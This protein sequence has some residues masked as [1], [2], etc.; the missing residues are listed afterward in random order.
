MAD[1]I[2]AAE[3]AAGV[4]A[5]VH[6]KTWRDIATLEKLCGMTA[7]GCVVHV[8]EDGIVADFGGPLFLECGKERVRVP[9]GSW[10]VVTGGRLVVLDAPTYFAL[11]VTRKT[12][13]EFCDE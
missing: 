7:L 10:V 9:R 13:A 8:D 11:F 3:R 1:G 2:W 6:L 12:W 5:A 4:S